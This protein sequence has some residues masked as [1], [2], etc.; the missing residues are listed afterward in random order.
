MSIH[1]EDGYMNINV[2]RNEKGNLVST[3]NSLDHFDDTPI[4][5]ESDCKG[6]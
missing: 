6:L 3:S 2:S 5:E 1:V 4:T